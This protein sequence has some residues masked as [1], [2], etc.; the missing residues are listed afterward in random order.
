MSETLT[1]TTAKNYVG[2]DWRDSA[3]GESYEKRNP[4][5]PSQVTGVFQASDAADGRTAVAAAGEAF[6]AWAALPLAQRAAYFGKAAAAIEARGEQIAQDM[7]AEMGKPLREARL[8][9]MRAATILRFAAAQAW[10]PIGELYEPSVPA[11]RLYTLRRPLGVVALITPWNFPIAIPVWKLAPALIGNTVVL[12]LGY[13]APLTGLH[14]AECFAEAGLPAESSTSSAAPGRRSERA[15]PEPGRPRDLVTGSVPSDSSVRDEATARNCRVQL[16]S[17]A[18]TRSSSWPTPS[19][20]GLSRPPTQVRSGLP[21]RSARPRAG[22]GPGCRLRRLRE[23]ML[24]RMA[25]GK[26]GDPA[27][28]D[29]EVGPV[30]NEGAMEEVLAAIRVPAATAPCSPAA[31]ARTTTVT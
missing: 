8:E 14:V 30:V 11:Q 22:S 31:S 26:V 2:G 15:C 27:D 29:V 7:T 25:A 18:R 23:R 12:K 10:R 16:E 24:A 21:A 3:S 6:P 19:S 9:A 5:R 1:T 13:E 28:P 4:W 17:A 20:T